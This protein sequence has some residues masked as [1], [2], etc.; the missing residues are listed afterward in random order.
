MNFTDKHLIK[1]LNRRNHLH[2][3]MAA[4]RRSIKSI[5]T[6]RKS[7]QIHKLNVKHNLNLFLQ[8]GYSYLPSQGTRRTRLVSPV[9]SSSLLQHLLAFRAQSRS[10][11]IQIRIFS[12]ESLVGFILFLAVLEE[13]PSP[14]LDLV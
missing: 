11:L 6:S 4:G 12:L 13:Y 5:C 10:R 7:K 9:D 1:V 3:L 14:S 8:F 2:D